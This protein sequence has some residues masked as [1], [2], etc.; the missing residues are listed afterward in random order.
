MQTRERLAQIFV[1]PRF[2]WAAP[3]VEPP[4]ATMARA[5]QRAVLASAVSWWCA[6][7]WWC[8]RVELHPVLGTALHALGAARRVANSP[9]VTLW[10]C[11]RAHAQALQLR[12]VAFDA[13]DFLW[14]RPMPGADPRAH[15]AARA[16]SLNYEGSRPVDFDDAF[17]PDLPPGA[18]AA[19]VSARAVSLAMIPRSRRDYE[20]SPSIDLEAQSHA[21]WRKW[22][23]HL[24]D[25]QRSQLSIWRGGAVRTPTRRW[26]FRGRATEALQK[27]L[28]CD[29]V[30]ASA[31]HLWAEC[32][33]FNVQR[34]SL[35]LEYDF[36]RSW[37]GAQPRCT[38]KS[39]W[40]TSTS[41][42]MPPRSLDCSGGRWST[43]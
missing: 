36:H 25:L 24:S 20:G 1:R 27:C 31:R 39:G 18:H 38:S 14:V 33:R 22:V 37:W 17:R 9:S 42:R 28:F 30:R 2:L 26:A 15:A 29:C 3:L 34:Q 4:P 7:R 41:G 16:A 19:R 11:L 32:P 10:A 43:W 8:E 35:E 13:Q 6:G 40:I 23:G 12:V 21:L 5:L